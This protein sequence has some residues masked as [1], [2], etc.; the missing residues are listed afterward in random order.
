MVLVRAS[1]PRTPSSSRF[2]RPDANRTACLGTKRTSVRANTKSFLSYLIISPRYPE[3]GHSYTT[4]IPKNIPNGDYIIRHEIIALHFATKMNGAQLF[5]SCSQ[6]SITGGT[7]FSSLSS[8]TTAHGAT[9]PGGYEATDPGVFVPKVSVAL[10]SA[11]CVQ[12]QAL[13]YSL[14]SDFQVYT[15]KAYTF[16]GPQV[17]TFST[18]GSP[19][20]ATA[21]SSSS[22]HSPSPTKGSPY[23]PSHS[24][25]SSSI[26]TPSPSSGS[27]WCPT[28]SR[29]LPVPQGPQR[30]SRLSHG[31]HVRRVEALR[32][33]E[34][35]KVSE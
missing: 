11:Q 32:N 27:P 30:R 31:A 25:T 28:R 23:T 35:Q 18:S 20:N 2:P 4:T 26:P 1:I 34:L 12:V 24:P 10:L 13:G 22:S 5:P 8:A 9:F 29:V 7:D 15:S 21:Q 14:F 17:A 3:A 16:P 19:T 6:V 33:A